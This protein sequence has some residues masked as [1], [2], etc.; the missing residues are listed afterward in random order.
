MNSIYDSH[1]TKSFLRIKYK[2]TSDYVSDNSEKYK[3]SQLY[4]DAGVTLDSQ[5][6]LR[7][8]GVDIQ[9]I[10]PVYLKGVK[11]VEILSGNEISS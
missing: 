6:R 11:G 2:R 4:G 10:G 5:G 7:V 3:H 1:T 8:Q 9:T